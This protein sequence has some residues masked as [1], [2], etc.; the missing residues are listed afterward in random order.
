MADEPSLRDVADAA[1][2]QAFVG[3]AAE[4]AALDE[5]L[6]PSTPSRV[7]YVHGPGGI[8]KSALLRA[9]IRRAAAAGVTSTLLDARS[10]SILLDQLTARVL[11]AAAGAT[12]VVIDEADELG[13]ALAP[14]RDALLDELPGSARIVLAGRAAPDPSWRHGALHTVFRDVALAPLRAEE[15][16]ALLETRGVDDPARRAQLAEWAGGSPLALTVGASMLPS[17]GALDPDQELEQQLTQWLEGAP[18]LDIDADVLAVAALVR[19]VDARVLTAALPGRS[20]RESLQRLGELRVTQRLGVGVSL[21]PVLAAAIK[22]RLKTQSPDYYRAL[23]GRIV[24]HL[25]TRARLGDIEAL[26]EMTLFIESPQLRDAI[27]MDASPS[28]YADRPRQGEVAEF[29]RANGFTTSPQWSQ[30]AEF[31][32]LPGG[33]DLVMRR[34][35]GSAVFLSV[36]RQATDLPDTPLGRDL[37]AS[38]RATGAEPTLAFGGVVLFA[39]VPEYD[40]A[41]ATRIAIGAFTRRY[42]AATMEAILLHYPEPARRPEQVIAQLAQPFDGPW[43]FEIYRSDFRP[44][45]AVGFVE[46]AVY[47]DLGTPPPDASLAELL[48]A[49]DDPVRRDR[50]T[51][52]LDDTFGSSVDERR[53]RRTIELAHLGPRRSEQECLDELHVSRATWFRLL[54][55]ARERVLAYRK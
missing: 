21:H 15:A 26:L 19:S 8:G 36:L 31:L 33:V 27:G 42:R 17:A 14:L 7:L 20:T 45:G 24:H 47:A 38:A 22:Q 25:G 41:E 50:L 13:S 53:L 10:L 28:H 16:E 6:D 51:R 37:A 43:E 12:L 30:I 35:D 49:D 23:A 9:A 40:R 34:N 2:A 39:D 54:R 11:D 1:D 3:R 29:A 5:L 32:A 4:L 46:R 52:V 55:E 44:G 48:A 18:T